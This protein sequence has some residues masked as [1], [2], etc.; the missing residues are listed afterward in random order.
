MALLPTRIRSKLILIVLVALVPTAV[1]FI[2]NANLLRGDAQRRATADQVARA[3]LRA[4]GVGIIVEDV[5]ALLETLSAVPDVTFGNPQAAQSVLGQVV[6]NSDNL[7]VATLVDPTGRVITSSAPPEGTVSVAE[8][9]WFRGARASDEYA[10]GTLQRLALVETTSVVVA[11][12]VIPD[13]P[14]SDIIA[15]A[16]DVERLEDRLRAVPPPPGAI[17]LLVTKDGRIVARSHDRLGAQGEHFLRTARTLNDE[18]VFRAIGVDGTE[19]IYTTA[20]VPG[21]RGEFYFIVGI[22]PDRMFSTFRW[23]LVWSLLGLLLVGVLAA[24]LAWVLGTR[25]F[26]RPIT[27]LVG[28]AHLLG[29]RRFEARHALPTART[30][31]FGE[32]ARELDRMSSQL[33]TQI[34]ELE[35]ARE[36]LEDLNVALE[37]RVR[38]R[39]ADLEASNNELQAFSYSVSHDLRTPLRSISGFAQELVDSDAETLT[40]QG[41]S[42]LMRIHAAAQRMSQLIDAMLKLS[43]VARA[44]LEPAEVDVTALATDI[45]T[46]YAER[47]V[48]RRVTW[49]VEP[50]LR[51]NGDPALVRALF[52]NLL[53]NAW[54]F[55]AE[56]P[57]AHIGVGRV[58]TEHGEAIF[59]R[60]NGAGFDM[61][62]ADK[63]FAPFQRLHAHEEYSGLG[64]GLA[65]S[66]RIARRH[67]GDIWVDAAPGEG[68]TFYV[69]FDTAGSTSDGSA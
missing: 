11:R 50:G 45:L 34:V 66:A 65:T 32:L 29:E 55:T 47:D 24:A 56:Q 22:D 31:E 46:E 62:Y 10:V 69:T 25:W 60:D 3:E 6:A 27:Q 52:D 21:S 58:A 1:L 68:A 37:R 15:A 49:E 14:D 43:R 19:R 59:V 9:D 61:R 33:E 36:R 53:G 44:A 41:R 38:E 40:E 5:V 2:V 17:G 48:A 20:D 64:I 28:A 67:G 18:D 26:L 42:D 54:K 39:T 8:R 13:D 16:I 51:L 12:R 7:I 4:Q 63:L 30:D 23:T 35:D 57:D